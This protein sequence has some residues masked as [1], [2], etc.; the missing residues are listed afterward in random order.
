MS[1]NF[2]EAYNPSEEPKIHLLTH[3][4]FGIL[5]RLYGA[6][7]TFGTP[8]SAQRVAAE[9]ERDPSAVESQI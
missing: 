7:F 9:V 8:P 2:P 4:S 6:G 1:S 3:L 5:L